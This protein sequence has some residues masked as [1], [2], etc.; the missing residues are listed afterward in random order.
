M[1]EMENKDKILIGGSL[2]VICFAL[3]IFLNKVYQTPQ[4]VDK[5]YTEALNDYKNGDYSNSYYLFSKVTFLSDLKPFAIYHQA[6]AAKE[7]NDKESELKKYQTLFKNYP[8]HP[9][10]LR[11][12]YLSAQMLVDDNPKLAE[13]Y[14][15]YIIK[16]APNSDYAIAAEYYAGLLLMKQYQKDEKSIFPLS[17]K[18]EVENYFRHYLKK[19]PSGRL[20]LSVIENWLS[21]DKE[22][23]PDDY[24]LMAKS[25]YE[26][27]EYPRVKEL[28]TKTSLPESWALDVKNSY[29]MGNYPRAKFLTE[30][31]LEKYSGYVDEK[32]IFNAI[33]I[34]INLSNDTKYNTTLKLYSKAGKKGGDYLMNL[35]CRYSDSSSQAQCYKHLYLKY[36]KGQ[37]AA[38]ALSQVFLSAIRKG[39]FQNA[40]K[41]GLDHLNKFKDANSTPMVMYWM[42]RL[43]EKTH[44]YSEYMGYYKSVITR[45]PDNY[46]AYRAFLK[47]NHL[48]G[49]IITDYIKDAP[50]EYPYHTKSSLIK[51]LAALED[52][53]VLYEISGSDDFIRS[54][55]LY[56]KGDYSHSTL[57]ARDAMD[58]LEKKPDKYDLRWRL[59]YPVHYY[60][61][62]KKY[63]SQTGN[64]A[65]LILALIRE[66]SYF[67]PEAV[68]SVGAKGLMQIMPATASEI[69]AKKGLGAY[70]LFNPSSNIKVGNYYYAFIKSLSGGFDI[71]AVA[72]Y[73]GGIGSVTRWKNSLYYN[74]TDDFVEQIPYPETKNYVKKVFRSYWNYIR[75]YNG[76]S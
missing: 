37:F 12:R 27:G 70:S 44:N 58:E 49:S 51:R 68:S 53:D 40:K 21:L 35:R 9:L 3:G 47:L 34:Y 32:D 65:P 42:G 1:I 6:E 20:A 50:V 57:V 76:N 28:L 38:D 7:L 45:Y 62:I 33:D 39:D 23:S 36:S 17:K 59:V 4:R 71:P 63:T 66:E 15:E 14:F 46:Y 24:L 67:N 25:L 43:A 64:N 11:A 72:S 5:I 10:A 16:E 22:I 41:I 2:V 29:V 56:K 73:N 55:V 26:F 31:G 74:D 19:A 18:E 60:D 69:S 52:F 61:D 48:N 30:A 75:I 13:D 8:N 54:W